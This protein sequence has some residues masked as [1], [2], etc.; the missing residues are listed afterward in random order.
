MLHI[1]TPVVLLIHQVIEQQ[2]TRGYRY[3][4]LARI[5]IVIGFILLI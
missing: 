2:K 3:N 5:A 1:F 4:T